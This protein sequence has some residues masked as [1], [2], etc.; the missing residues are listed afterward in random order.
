MN[1]AFLLMAQFE[2]PTVALKDI[3]LQYLGMTPGE[4]QRE[5][6]MNRLPIPTFRLRDSQKAP[7]LIHVDD[8]AKHID[9]IRA[10]ATAAWQNSQSKRAS[11]SSGC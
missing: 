10:T 6:N 7:L 5:A 1:T 2:S 4:A 3:A 11:I 8:L 9:K